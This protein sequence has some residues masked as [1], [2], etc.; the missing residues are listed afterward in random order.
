MPWRPH[1]PRSRPARLSG[2]LG[3]SVLAATALWAVSLAAAGPPA[4]GAAAAIEL[5]K[6]ACFDRAALG[7]E[8]DR[9]LE[10]PLGPAASVTVR[11]D[12]NRLVI[13]S[14]SGAV[15]KDVTGWSC[16]QRLDFAAVSV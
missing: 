12:T 3:L 5:T 16:K 1:K 10:Q 2:A 6:S 13:E 9:Y 7:A 4:P 11:D 8:V 14:A 15:E